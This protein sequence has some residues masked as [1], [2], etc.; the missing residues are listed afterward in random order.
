MSTATD[1]IDTIETAIRAEGYTVKRWEGREV[2]LYVSRD[3]REFGYLTAAD[4]GGTGTCKHVQKSGM[5]AAI[6]RKAIGR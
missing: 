1:R 6:I 3:G 5:F 4:D 2:R